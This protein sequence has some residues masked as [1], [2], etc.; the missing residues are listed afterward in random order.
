MCRTMKLLGLVVCACVLVSMTA[1]RKRD[2]AAAADS[3]KPVAAVAADSLVDDMST[4]PAGWF[5][6]KDA[7]TTANL[8]AGKGQKGKALEL[9]YNFNS[10]NWLGMRKKIEKDLTG[11]KGIRFA[12]RGEGAANSIEVKLENADY[13]NFGTV[14]P[15]KSNAG[16]WTMVEINFADMQYLW[17]NSQALDLKKP[18][19][20]IAVVKKDGDEGATGKLIIDQIELF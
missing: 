8:T 9:T 18:L 14:L 5:P 10:G 1:A 19:L 2:A 4:A 7:G 17:G 3:K 6:E 16:A 12:V 11:K 13:T 15:V 20:H